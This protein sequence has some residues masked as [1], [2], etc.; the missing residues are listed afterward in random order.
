MNEPNPNYR[1]YLLRLWQDHP[2]A[3]WRASAQ[4]VQTNEITHFADLDN[5]FTFL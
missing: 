4:C 2:R 5:L 1:S 3:M